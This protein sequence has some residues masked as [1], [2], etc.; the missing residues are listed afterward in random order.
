MAKFSH[1]ATVCKYITP[2]SYPDA[3]EERGAVVEFPK[4]KCIYFGDVSRNEKGE[5]VLGG[6]RT[7]GIVGIGSTLEE[8]ENIAQKICSDIKGPVRF[9]SDI[10][11]DTLV[12]QRIDMMNALRK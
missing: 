11:T 8:A 9:R 4:E 6:S 2:K 10:G 1:K 7:A 5:T 12:Q 3:K